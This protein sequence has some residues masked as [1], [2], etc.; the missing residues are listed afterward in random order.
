[1]PPTRK[2]Y[3]LCPTCSAKVCVKLRFFHCIR[4]NKPLCAKCKKV[5]AT[6][7]DGSMFP[8]DE[9]LDVTICS[10][11]KLKWLR[12]LIFQA[13]STI[14]TIRS[15][16]TVHKELLFGLQKKEST[17]LLPDSQKYRVASK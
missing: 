11:C 10:R 4:C 12:F 6:S 5:Q 15:L 2:N 16:M 17:S 13:E 14:F 9:H 3:K 1:M 8:K 7:P